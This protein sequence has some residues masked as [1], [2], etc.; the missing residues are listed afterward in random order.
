MRDD[1]RLLNT[2]LA[3][4]AIGGLMQ[5]AAVVLLLIRWLA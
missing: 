3:L 5:I 2:L 1:T 4:G